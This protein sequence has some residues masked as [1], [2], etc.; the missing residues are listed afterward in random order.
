MIR[1][2]LMFS[3]YPPR[4]Q[5]ILY[6]SHDA[7]CAQPKVERRR[8]FEAST[9]L[10]LTSNVLGITTFS[11]SRA[12]G[13]VGGLF[14]RAAGGACRKLSSRQAPDFGIV[15]EVRNFLWETQRCSLAAVNRLMMMYHRDRCRKLSVGLRAR[16]KRRGYGMWYADGIGSS[17]RTRDGR[18][19]YESIT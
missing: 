8:F 12:N 10:L 4:G 13:I 2:W 19:D 1:V 9:G 7:L 5:S 3:F 11:S 16:S 17:G 18:N 6:H 15:H 14:L